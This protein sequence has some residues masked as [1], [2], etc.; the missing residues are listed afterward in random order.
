M[1]AVS[2]VQGQSVTAR[3]AWEEAAAVYSQLLKRI[4][5]NPQAQDQLT[6]VLNQLQTVQQQAGHYSQAIEA[7][8]R[9]LELRK[10]S[11]GDEHPLT[12][13][14]KSDLGALYGATGNFESALPL[15]TAALQYWQQHNPPANLKWGPGIE[16]SG[17]CRTRCRFIQRRTIAFRES[18]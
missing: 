11:F 10:S 18:P 9:L 4:E 12:I 1:A 5:A 17:G 3:Q 2:S 15:L 16:R 8:R 6:V 13:A 7:C 14:A